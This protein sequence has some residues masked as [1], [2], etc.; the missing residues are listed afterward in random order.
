MPSL[1]R[2]DHVLVSDGLAVLAARE[3]IGVT[4]DHRPAIADLVVLPEGR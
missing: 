3:G 2:L 4:T 1:F